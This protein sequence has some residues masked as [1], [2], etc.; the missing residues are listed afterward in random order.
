MVFQILVGAELLA[1]AVGEVEDDYVID[2]EEEEEED[3]GD[4]NELVMLDPSHVSGWGHTHAALSY[5]HV[6]NVVVCFLVPC[7]H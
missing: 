4:E 3:L 7:S 1:I 6:V 2:E 5:M